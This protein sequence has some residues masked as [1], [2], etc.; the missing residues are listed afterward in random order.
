MDVLGVIDP[1][2]NDRATGNTFDQGR[3]KQNL[4]AKSGTGDQT[5][6]VAKAVGGG[7]EL[8]AKPAFRPAK[9]LG[10]RPPFSLRAP[11]AC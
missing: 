5:D 10:I 8:G 4:A 11:P 6:E 1:V 3:A 9:T 7:V 2:G